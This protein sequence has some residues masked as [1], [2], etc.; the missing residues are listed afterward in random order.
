M[1]VC[2]AVAL[3]LVLVAA[4]AAADQPVA[5]D[6]KNVRTIYLGRFGDSDEAERFRMVL[7]IELPRRGFTLVH[8]LNDADAE[9]QGVL[10]IHDSFAGPVVSCTAELINLRNDRLWA[11][12]YGPKTMW[13]PAP[14]PSVRDGVKQIGEA[15]AKALAKAR[16]KK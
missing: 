5:L 10:T 12:G 3:L 2:R 13:R 16:A 8:V 6:L 9:L 7:S 15:I 14:W 4:A 1:R 11:H